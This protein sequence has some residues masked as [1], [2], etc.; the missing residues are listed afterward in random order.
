[1]ILRSPVDHPRPV[2]SQSL[3]KPR[4]QLGTI[5]SAQRQ[6]SAVFE[7][8]RMISVRSDFQLSDTICIDNYRTMH[9]HIYSRIEPLV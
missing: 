8:Y 6:F 7:C 9:A 2:V 5:G 3:V 1:M 4:L